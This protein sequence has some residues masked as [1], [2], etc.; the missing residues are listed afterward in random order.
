MMQVNIIWTDNLDAISRP[1]GMLKEIDGFV[2]PSYCQ[3]NPLAGLN[4]VLLEIN[5]LSWFPLRWLDCNRHIV[6]FG[7]LTQSLMQFIFM[8]LP[9][10]IFFVEIQMASCENRY[11]VRGELTLCFPCGNGLPRDVNLV[12]EL[13]LR[14]LVFLSM[15]GNCLTGGHDSF[16]LFCGLRNEN[17]SPEILL[18]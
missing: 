12:G 7:K 8:D 16:L 4:Y 3:R 18:L 10:Q 15:F 1:W 13:L 5:H 9:E 17:M 2:Y 14:Q 11:C 6:L